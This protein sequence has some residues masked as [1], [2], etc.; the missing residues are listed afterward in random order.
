[1]RIRNILLWI[2]IIVLILLGVFFLSDMIFETGLIEPVNGSFIGDVGLICG[3]S[4]DCPSGHLRY[5]CTND[6]ERCPSYISYNCKDRK[7]I[8][9]IGGSEA[10]CFICE[11]GCLDG[12]CE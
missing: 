4:A 11:K 6:N 7:C 12:V 1:M 3:S 5:S 8:E 9:E 10:P 2:I